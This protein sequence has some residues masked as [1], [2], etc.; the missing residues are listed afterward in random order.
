MMR[1]LQ[2]VT[3]LMIAMPI[4]AQTLASLAGR[5]RVLLIFA[6]SGRDATV[7]R[8]IALLAHHS[9][10]LKQRDVTLLPV[11]LDQGSPIT[12]DTLR[13]ATAFADLG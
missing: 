5:H 6:S 8:Q 12:A 7:Q 9:A 11:F 1:L 4:H 3:V 2:A 10:E 13:R